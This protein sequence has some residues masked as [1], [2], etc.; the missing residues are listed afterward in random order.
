MITD[1]ILRLNYYERQF[2]G[3][4]DFQDEQAYHIEMR[5]RHHLAHHTWGAVTGL[6]IVKDATTKIWSV[7]PGFAIDGRGREIVVSEAEALDTKVIGDRLAGMALPAELKVWIAYDTETAEPPPPG[8][9]AC[10]VANQYTRLRETFRLIYKDD[11][12]GSTT[13]DPEPPFA[14]LSDDPDAA[15]WPIW[16]GTITWDR[17]PADV[18][19]T[20]ITNVDAEGRRYAG[21]VAAELSAP[22]VAQ[23]TPAGT[24][25]KNTLTVRADQTRATGMASGARTRVIVEGDVEV[26]GEIDF[27]TASGA[28]NSAPLR[29]LRD[30][31]KDLRLKIGNTD[32]DGARLVV[33]A[34]TDQKLVVSATGDAALDGALTIK[35]S[36]VLA[37]N[38]GRINLRNQDETETPAITDISRKTTASGADLR[39]GIGATASPARLVVGPKN[40]D[41]V[42]EKFVVENDGDVTIAGT[43][44]IGGTLSVTGNINPGA[45]VAGRDLVADGAKLDTI[46]SGAKKTAIAG[47]TIWDGQTISLPAGF[48]DET[49]C[50]WLVSP[51]QSDVTSWAYDFYVECTLNSRLVRVKFWYRWFWFSPW[52]SFPW[53]A[54]YI[55]VGVE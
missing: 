38:G 19:K 6:D 46:S 28:E 12:P 34:G 33:G 30:G 15:P 50:R 16:L 37:M 21:L 13:T 26:D 22:T 32:A 29:A 55:I 44:S 23:N 20:V 17:D 1:D 3:S 11:P 18:T 5:R 51:V 54:N 14:D 43:A 45:R 25:F 2:L 35:S 53:Q 52:V 41:D 31:S 24:L 8:F 48:T 10:G 7:Q 47:G 39:L 9:E 36:K 27:R 49:K 4:R 42:G 40:G